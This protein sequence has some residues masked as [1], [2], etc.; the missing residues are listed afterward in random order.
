[1]KVKITPSILNG[2]FVAPPSKSFAHRYILA[3]F[4][5]G[6]KTCVSNVGDSKDVLATLGAIASVGAEYE[7]TADGV[8]IGGNRDTPAKSVFCNE[9]GTTLRLIMP[10]LSALG[11]KTELTGKPSLLSRPNEK[12]ISA[13]NAHGAEIDGYR[14]NG[15]LKSGRF[16]IDAGISSQYVSGLLF[17]LPLLDGDSEIVFKGKPVSERY[18]EITVDVLNKFG[19]KAEKTGNGYF[20]YGNQKYVSPKKVCVEGDY[21]SSAFFLTAGA[22]GGKIVAKNLNPRSKQGDSVILDLLSEVGAKVEREGDKVA[23]TAGEIKPFFFDGK[24]APDVIQIVSV[25]ACFAG[26]KSVIKGVDRLRIKES[27]RL[28]G[29]TE[30]LG[31]C[32]IRY[33][34]EDDT[35]TVY[36]GK[37]LGAEYGGDNDHRTVMSRIILATYSVGESSVSGAEAIDKSYPDFLGD[38]VKLGGKANVSI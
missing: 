15:K 19:I 28:K 1:M 4:L 27:D 29:I 6:D 30:M 17:A 21:S 31:K 18:I 13:L 35:L 9:S 23:V 26:G 38:Y 24:D 20:V 34:Y 37:P 7:K 25:L 8:I 11:Y 10:V 22:L 3:S 2:E 12:L 36:G 16:E 14:L 33:E 5:S 32:K